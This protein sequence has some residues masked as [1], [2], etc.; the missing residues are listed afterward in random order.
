MVKKA[1][2]S[3]GVIFV[4][5]PKMHDIDCLYKDLKIEE[6]LLNKTIKANQE[7]EFFSPF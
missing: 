7:I 5:L 1:P 6:D 4:D 3:N 2:R